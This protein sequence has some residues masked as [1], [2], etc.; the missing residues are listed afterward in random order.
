MYCTIPFFFMI[1]VNAPSPFPFSK[2]QN[3]ENPLENLRVDKFV[4]NRNTR[5]IL[6]YRWHSVSSSPRNPALS[7]SSEFLFIQGLNNVE[8][9]SEPMH[10]RWLFNYFQLLQYFFKIWKLKWP[11]LMTETVTDKLPWFPFMG[12]SGWDHFYSYLNFSRW[13]VLYIEHLIEKFLSSQ[14]QIF[15]FFL[16]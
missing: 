14:V 7:L 6:L 8:D 1:N 16:Y 13:R 9:K 11:S 3:K 2:F 15:L 12:L 10:F 4:E 5:V